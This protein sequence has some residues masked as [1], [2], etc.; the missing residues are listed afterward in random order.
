MGRA[1]LT[2]ATLQTGSHHIVLI[3]VEPAKFVLCAMLARIGGL[4]DRLEKLLASS[5]HSTTMK[6]HVTCF[7]QKAG[8]EPRTLGTKAE[9][10]DRCATRPVMDRLDNII[11]VSSLQYS[12]QWWGH[13][14]RSIW[15][16]F[17][18]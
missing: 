3:S 4:V 8:F 18:H 13:M 9:R 7:V 12:L 5:W 15:Q 11:T 1:G 10:N 6:R 16:N 14:S 2:I 17:G